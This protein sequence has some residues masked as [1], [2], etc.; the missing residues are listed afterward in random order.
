MQDFDFDGDI[1]EAFS[2]TADYKVDSNYHDL[3]A[4]LPDH[5]E[6]LEEAEFNGLLEGCKGDIY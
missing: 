5:A 6:W 1:T 4:W 3:L 2:E